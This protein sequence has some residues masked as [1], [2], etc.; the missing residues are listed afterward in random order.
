MLVFFF[1]LSTNFGREEAI[2]L[3]FGVSGA[4]D[5]G[6]GDQKVLPIVVRSDKRFMMNGVVYEGGTFTTKLRRIIHSDPSKVLVLKAENGVS[7][8]GIVAAM[9]LIRLAGGTH[10]TM[11]Q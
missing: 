4:A 7:V 10:V 11:A 5:A 9:D 6:Q 3:G 1:M 2:E 8:Q